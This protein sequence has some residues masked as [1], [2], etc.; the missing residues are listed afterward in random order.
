MRVGEVVR[1]MK[2]EEEKR[3]RTEREREFQRVDEESL[4]LL[5]VFEL[6][7]RRRALRKILRL[8]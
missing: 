6:G 2:E 4:I 7:G 1:E 5:S 8:K 3:E